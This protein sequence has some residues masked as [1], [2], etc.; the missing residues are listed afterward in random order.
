[1]KKNDRFVVT[2]REGSELS[3]AGVRQVLVDRE[4]GVNYLFVKAGY[5]AGITSLLKA[6]GTPV[7][8]R[9]VPEEDE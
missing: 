3:T 6:D 7:I 1:M 2:R 4:T 5:G 9:P 8:T